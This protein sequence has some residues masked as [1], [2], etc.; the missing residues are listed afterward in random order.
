MTKKRKRVARKRRA[1]AN[2]SGLPVYTPKIDALA[3]KLSR[4]RR[5]SCEEARRDIELRT[6]PRKKREVFEGAL[7]SWVNDTYKLVLDELKNNLQHAIV[8]LGQSDDPLTAFR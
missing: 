8:K 3:D 1:P 4:L 6:A 5:Q 7:S 2:V